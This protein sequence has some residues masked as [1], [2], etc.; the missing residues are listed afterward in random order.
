MLR[1]EMDIVWRL[2]A[3]WEQ[4]RAQDFLSRQ[5]ILLSV[6]AFR[7]INLQE[8]EISMGLKWLTYAVTKARQ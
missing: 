4:R 7:A 8:S 3:G 2:Y 1:Q 5:L 6:H